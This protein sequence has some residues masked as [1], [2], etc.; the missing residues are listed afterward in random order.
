MAPPR[1]AAFC[2]LEKPPVFHQRIRPANELDRAV[3]HVIDCDCPHCAIARD[4]LGYTRRT[5]IVRLQGAAL[6]LAAAAFVATFL[7][8]IPGIVAAFAA[9][10]TGVR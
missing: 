1:R 3:I 10:P 6:S 7:Y 9:A 5:G 4:P 8:C 2:C